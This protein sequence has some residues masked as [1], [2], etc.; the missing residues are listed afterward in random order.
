MNNMILHSEEIFTFLII[1]FTTGDDTLK[2]YGAK[3]LLALIVANTF[4]IAKFTKLKFPLYG[5]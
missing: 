2:I 5:T 1:M 3:N 4:K